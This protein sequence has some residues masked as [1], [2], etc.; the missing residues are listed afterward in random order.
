MTISSTW[1]SP[2][3]R[4]LASRAPQIAD[5]IRSE[6]GETLEVVAREVGLEITARDEIRVEPISPYRAT[7]HGNRTVVALGDLASDQV[8]EVV[9][10]L[11]FPYGD[12]GRDIGAIVSLTDRDGVFAR[13]GIASAAPAR[14]TWGYAHDAAN[15]GQVRDR[16]VDRVVARLFAARARQ[17]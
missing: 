11:S 4:R 6:V 17:D 3:R 12:I 9:L 8:V 16:V 5:A 1:S 2:R 10:R 7:T 15:D 13:G 14:L